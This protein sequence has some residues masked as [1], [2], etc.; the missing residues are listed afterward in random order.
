MAVAPVA[1][2]LFG[3]V[4]VKVAPEVVEAPVRVTLVAVQ[5]SVPDAV[6]VTPAG[7]VVVCVTV[8]EAVA[9]H[10]VEGLVAVTV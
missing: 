1:V 6:A 5:V 7:A 8:V 10:P 3:P 2:K 9:L 4:Q